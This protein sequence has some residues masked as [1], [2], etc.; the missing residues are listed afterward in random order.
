MAVTS[1]GDI[2]AKPE[3]GQRTEEHVVIGLDPRNGEN[4]PSLT[5]GAAVEERQEVLSKNTTVEMADAMTGGKSIGLWSSNM[6]EKCENIGC[7][8]KQAVADTG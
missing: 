6:P 8:E 1:S 2:S 4:R 7:Q 5:S 3:R